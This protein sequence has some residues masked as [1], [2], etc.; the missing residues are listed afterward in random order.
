MFQPLNMQRHIRQ[1][2]VCGDIIQ[3]P[4][5]MRAMSS[6]DDA[7][8]WFLIWTQ[9]LWGQTYSAFAMCIYI[10]I[11]IYYTYIYFFLYSVY[12]MDCVYSVYMCIYHIWC[13]EREVSAEILMI[14]NRNIQ[15]FYLQGIIVWKGYHNN[16][17]AFVSS[18]H[19]PFQWFRVLQ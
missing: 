18:G 4:D 16:S 2:H 10:Y 5:V 12:V 9:K 8:L 1:C 11:I 3:T 17:L 7:R 15:A 13:T 19:S 14:R 6:W